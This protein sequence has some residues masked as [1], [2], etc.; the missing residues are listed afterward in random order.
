MTS[1]NAE[2]YH[3]EHDRKNEQYERD[4]EKRETESEDD[5]CSCYGFVSCPYPTCERRVIACKAA[6]GHTYESGERKCRDCGKPIEEMYGYAEM[7][8]S[9]DSERPR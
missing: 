9:A 1:V 8:A 5:G 4:L 3:R 2:L 7:L 6:G